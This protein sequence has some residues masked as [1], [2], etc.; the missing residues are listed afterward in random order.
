MKHLS[1]SVAGIGLALVV[2]SSAFAAGLGGIFSSA[3]PG[4]VG[5]SIS[6]V[7]YGNTSNPSGNGNG[8]LPSF[9][10]GPWK[11][12]DPSDCAGPTTAGS[13]MGEIFA[14]IASGGKSSPD[15]ANGKLIGQDF[16]AH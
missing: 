12:T 8:V 5:P 1:V 6:G 15:F 13:S 10:P 14:P 7:L 2:S 4:A 11:C 3:P 16:S 9:A